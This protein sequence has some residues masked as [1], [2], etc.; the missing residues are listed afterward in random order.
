MRDTNSH[1]QQ[2][3]SRR[4]ARGL[5]FSLF[6]HALLVSEVRSASLVS[7]PRLSSIRTGS[8]ARYSLTA[9]IPHDASRALP[10]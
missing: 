10:V 4:I 6:H 5:V 3:A 7:A 2:N 1:R 9:P 8:V